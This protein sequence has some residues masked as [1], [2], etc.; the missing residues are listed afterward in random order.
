MISALAIQKYFGLKHDPFGRPGESEVFRG[1]G[2]AETLEQ[3]RE[4]LTR[5]EM[6]ALIGAPGSGKTTLLADLEGDSDDGLKVIPVVF[7]NRKEMHAGAVFELIG[8]EFG[9][10]FSRSN[11]IRQIE[12]ARYLADTAERT[13]VAVIVDEA[14]RVTSEFL[15]QMKEL[16]EMRWGLKRDLLGVCF[17]GLPEFEGLAR[18]YAPDIYRRLIVQR[19]IIDAAEIVREEIKE[20][21]QFRTMAAGNR[22]LMDEG[23][24]NASAALARTPLEANR[25]A[26]DAMETAH[27]AGARQVSAEHVLAG[28]TSRQKKEAL[29]LTLGE[30]GAATGMSV[31]AAS[32]AINGESR[33]PGEAARAVEQ[34][35]D[36]AMAAGRGKAANA[37]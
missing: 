29:G 19:K 13:R 24:M 25:V 36:K 20:Y 6:V 4:W 33:G 1:A 28:R 32:R 2:F 35:L 10:R 27:K 8:L 18:R 11:A 7:P 34:F 14:H 30:I 17:A 12:L 15:R 9:V 23:A 22:A 5:G 3:M 31:A 21:L 26:W 37:I 16:S